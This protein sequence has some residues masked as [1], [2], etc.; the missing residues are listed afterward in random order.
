MEVAVSEDVLMTV[1]PG[2]SLDLDHGTI[3]TI[4]PSG[5]LG[6]VLRSA[7]R[8]EPSLLMVVETAAEQNRVE[9][10]L[11]RVDFGLSLAVQSRGCAK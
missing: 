6:A 3:P 9:Q 2:E 5:C 8:S 1:K 11:L 4:F 7:I 10:F